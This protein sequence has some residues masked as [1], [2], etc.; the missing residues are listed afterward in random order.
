MAEAEEEAAQL[1]ASYVDVSR[2]CRNPAVLLTSIVLFA[3]VVIKATVPPQH[4]NKAI[5]M[6]AE[7]LREQANKP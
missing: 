3:S 5:H 1:A 2:G 7:K 6:I 4:R